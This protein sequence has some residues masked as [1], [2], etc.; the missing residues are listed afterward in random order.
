VDCPSTEASVI[1]TSGG[2]AAGRSPRGDLRAARDVVID[3]ARPP[4]S[5][6]VRVV[7][8]IGPEFRPEIEAALVPA[9]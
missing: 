5:S 1:H 7:G 9:G 8:L 6:L 3:T 2:H 4:A